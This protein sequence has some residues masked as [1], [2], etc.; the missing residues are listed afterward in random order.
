M[1]LTSH[2]VERYQLKLKSLTLVPSYGGVF[3]VS[4]NGEQVYSNRQTGRFPTDQEIDA[5]IDERLAGT[6]NP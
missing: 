3:N 6:K 5:A 1:S 4:I 2:L